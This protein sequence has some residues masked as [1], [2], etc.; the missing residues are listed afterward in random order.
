VIRPGQPMETW[1]LDKPPELKTLQELVG[2]Y[3]EMVPRFTS[4]A[5][6]ACIAYCNEDGKMKRLPVNA[7]MTVLWAQN[8]G[9]TINMMRDELRGPIVVISGDREFME[10]Q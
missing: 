7:E 8:L 10:A 2:G 3:I 9:T 4:F 6:E 1:D 5:G